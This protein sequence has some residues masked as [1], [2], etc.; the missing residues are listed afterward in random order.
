MG[1][2]PYYVFEN[3]FGKQIHREYPIKRRL[4]AVT[5]LNLRPSDTCN[6][7]GP[8]LTETFREVLCTTLARSSVVDKARRHWP[9]W[10]ARRRP[11]L[12]CIVLFLALQRHYLRGF[13]SGALKG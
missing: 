1:L 11:A 9:S 10:P 5:P 4:P 6:C 3:V 12:P 8:K 13:M 7:A 2:P